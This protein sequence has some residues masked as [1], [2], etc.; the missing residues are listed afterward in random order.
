MI[1]LNLNIDA[2]IKVFRN[3]NTSEEPK[4]EKTDQDIINE[5]NKLLAPSLGISDEEQKQI[6]ESIMQKLDP[7]ENKR[8]PVFLASLTTLVTI[9]FYLEKLDKENKSLFKIIQ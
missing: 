3:K 8:S 2:L 9:S 6:K 5:A 1:N 7:L 4:K